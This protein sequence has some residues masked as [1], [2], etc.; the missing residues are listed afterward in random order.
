MNVGNR[1]DG[2]SRVPVIRV[3]F[4]IQTLT[5]S[6]SQKLIDSAHYVLETPAAR[7]LVE[8]HWTSKG[9]KEHPSRACFDIGFELLAYDPEFQKHID[10]LLRVLK[11]NAL[12]VQNLTASTEVAALFV[13]NINSIETE[14]RPHFHLSKDQVA[15]LA[16]LG[17]SIDFDGYL[18]F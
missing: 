8:R 13:V 2:A 10:R 14:H 4:S 17:A 18:M 1:Q 6:I 12:T 9:S 5:G 7:E 15:L 3:Y 11:D 16:S